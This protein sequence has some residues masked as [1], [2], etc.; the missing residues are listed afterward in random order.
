[1]DKAM[2][3]SSGKALIFAVNIDPMSKLY[4]QVISE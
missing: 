2:M 4:G 1:M 3:V